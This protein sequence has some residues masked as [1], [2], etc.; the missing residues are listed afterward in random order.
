MAP[1]LVPVSWPAYLRL[2]RKVS[3]SLLASARAA[4]ELTERARSPPYWPPTKS[5][6]SPRVTAGI[7]LSV[8]NEGKIE[9]PPRS[10]TLALERL[11]FHGF[12][13]SMGHEQKNPIQFDCRYQHRA[14]WRLCR[15]PEHLSGY[16]TG[17][18]GNRHHDHG[19]EGEG[20]IR[21]RA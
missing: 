1:A 13:Y 16:G 19:H 18:G 14:K 6:S 20:K 4:T 11:S 21:S 10:E 17:C 8:E 2:L 7:A 12:S 9:S 3:C 5:A 15:E